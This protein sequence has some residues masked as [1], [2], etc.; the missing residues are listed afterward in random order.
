VDLSLEMATEKGRAVLNATL[1]L[2]GPGTI[3]FA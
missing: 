3:Y 2:V 1:A